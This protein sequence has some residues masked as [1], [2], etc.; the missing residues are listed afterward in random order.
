MLSYPYFKIENM[1]ITLLVVQL[2]K[3]VFAISTVN[4]INHLSN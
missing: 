2:V 4:P 1:L 3:V